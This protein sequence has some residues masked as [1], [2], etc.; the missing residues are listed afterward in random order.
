M[1]ILI[2]IAICV[3]VV[4][5]VV[6]IVLLSTDIIG[7]ILLKFR[8]WTPSLSLLWEKLLLMAFTHKVRL[9]AIMSTGILE[10]SAIVILVGCLLIVKLLV[11]VQKVV[12]TIFEMLIIACLLT[13]TISD[14]IRLAHSYILVCKPINLL[15]ELRFP[16][17]L[18]SEMLSD[19][20]YVGLV[21]HRRIID[22][23]FDLEGLL[24]HDFLV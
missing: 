15:A 11:I 18:L 4:Y 8:L 7:K 6:K 24:L 2:E 13:T 23:R 1:N 21:R 9:L 3:Q 10:A 17:Q 19:A 22:N 12:L 20:Q 16:S 14:T 5:A